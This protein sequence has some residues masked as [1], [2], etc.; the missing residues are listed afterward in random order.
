MKTLSSPSSGSLLIYVHGT[1]G[2]GKSTLA[3]ALLAAAGGPFAI[4]TLNDNPKA[5][6][7]HTNEGVVFI[8]KYGTACG[9]V[10]G[11]SPYASINDIVDHHVGMGDPRM[12]AEGLI[13]PG[14][15]T[16]QRL[17]DKVDRHLY[18]FLDTPVEQCVENV[19]KRR[20]TKGNV[21][22]YDPDNL[23][24]KRRSA[25]SWAERLGKHGLQIESMTWIQAYCRC[26][27]MLD[28]QADPRNLL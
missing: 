14:V 4:G 5:S 2:S 20:R 24:K 27:Q 12:F 26:L 1:N 11:L 23:L 21:K 7:T 18:I 16:C 22:P 9:G 19:L 13:T 17:A 8:G 3:R 10:D 25:M 15:E 28:L 6:Y